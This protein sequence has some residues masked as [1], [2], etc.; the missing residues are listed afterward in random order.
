[1][2]SAKCA[3]DARDAVLRLG[4]VELCVED[5]S[6]V[7]LPTLERLYA[8]AF[9]RGGGAPELRLNRSRCASAPLHVE[10]LHPARRPTEPPE[11]PLLFMMLDRPLRG[12]LMHG[13]LWLSD[14]RNAAWVDYALAE[15]RIDVADRG[16]AAL[17]VTAHHTLPLVLGELLRLRGRYALHAAA[18]ARPDG[19]GVLLLGD[20]GCG[21]STLSYR[22]LDLGYRCVADDGVLLHD[23][24][25]RV[26][27]SPFYREHCL[28][29]SLLRADDRA[30]AIAIEPAIGGPRHRIDLPAS[31]LAAAAPLD[32]VWILRRPEGEP[33]SLEPA[34]AATL[35][36]E[37]VRQ[38]RR[39]L[40][41][42]ELAAA[43]IELLG[44]LTASAR[45][46][47]ARLGSGILRSDLALEELFA[48]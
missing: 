36:A 22:A 48:S 13:G 4:G 1:M 45:G 15:A 23:A 38:N 10:V 33:S 34:S 3:S 30:R 31:A 16:E 37:L 32:E 26:I 41:H 28:H 5:R 25:D 20:S 19:R 21:K 18:I 46:Y 14:G 9:T 11:E 2:P 35:L 24:G 42:P 27:A 39:V 44:R 29:P 40:L 17:Y 12:W 47:V 6:G 7:L 43:H 8:H